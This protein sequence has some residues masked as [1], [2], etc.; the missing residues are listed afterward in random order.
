VIGE[1]E[2]DEEAVEEE[3]DE[4]LLSVAG[5]GRD[6]PVGRTHRRGRGTPTD[7]VA[8]TRPRRPRRSAAPTSQCGLPPHGGNPSHVSR[9]SGDAFGIGRRAAGPRSHKGSRAM[10]RQFELVEQVKSYDPK[11]DEDALNRAY[12]YS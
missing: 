9:L 12:V 1:D 5:R 8:E 11:A 10:M 3:L 4:D 6:R 7:E 2:I